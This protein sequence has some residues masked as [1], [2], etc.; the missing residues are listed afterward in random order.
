MYGSLDSVKC[1]KH[2]C[3]VDTLLPALLNEASSPA[4]GV[5]IFPP[6]MILLE[7]QDFPNLPITQRRFPLSH[8]P[9]NRCVWTPLFQELP[10]WKRCSDII[11]GRI[12]DLEPKPV[13]L[14]S[15]I[16]YLPKISSIDVGPRISLS[17]LGV[18]DVLGEIA[19]ILVRLDHVA[20]SKSIDVGV[21]S[22]CKASGASF[23]YQL[24]YCVRVHWV[25][26]GV[27]V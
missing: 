11:V 26:V 4:F 25:Y 3:T 23:S 14:D 20:D 12:E 19:L 9:G 8:L 5:V 7:P 16:A 18:V 27:F 17:E 13:L 2:D 21:E 6:V 15:K 1:M 10:G 24:G 22:S